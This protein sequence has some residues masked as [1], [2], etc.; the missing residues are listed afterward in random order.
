VA[1]KVIDF[2]PT[3]RLSKEAFEAMQKAIA[4]MRYEDVT[5]LLVLYTPSDKRTNLLMYGLDFQSIGTAQALLTH[6]SLELL[7]DEFTT[8][9]IF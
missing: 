3:K 4:E 5:S 9:N 7:E 6:I 8:N 2:D 1:G